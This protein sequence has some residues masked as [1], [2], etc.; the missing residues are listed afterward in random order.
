MLRPP[1]LNSWRLTHR[2]EL[3]FPL[4]SGIDGWWSGALHT[5]GILRDFVRYRCGCQIVDASSVNIQRK[6][7]LHIVENERI[8][9]SFI[10][11]LNQEGD[12]A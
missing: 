10:R 4:A 3:I 6:S 1:V 5:D 8:S 2:R 11:F 9:I 12:P 7:W